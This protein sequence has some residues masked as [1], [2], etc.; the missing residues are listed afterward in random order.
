MYSPRMS[1]TDSQFIKQFQS[2]IEGNLDTAGISNDVLIEQIMHATAL[3]QR[4]VYCKNNS[5]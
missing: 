1:Q 5:V 4:F 2:C 3:R